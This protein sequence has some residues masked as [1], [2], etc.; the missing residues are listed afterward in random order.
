MLIS[1][2]CGAKTGGELVP[3]EHRSGSPEN[4][5]FACPSSPRNKLLSNINMLAELREASGDEL[6]LAID[7]C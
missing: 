4:L 5:C 1:L 6:A 3:I 2:R 7:E